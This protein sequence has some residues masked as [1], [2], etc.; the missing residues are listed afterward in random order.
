MFHRAGNERTTT[1]SFSIVAEL[2]RFRGSSDLGRQLY[3][4]V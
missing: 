1:I 2:D 4:N 3:R